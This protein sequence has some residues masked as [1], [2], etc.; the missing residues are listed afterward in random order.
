MTVTTTEPVRQ[1]DRV[2]WGDLLWLTWRQHRWS[3]V[4]LTAL[5]GAFAV[6]W[7]AMAWVVHD[8]GTTQHRIWLIGGLYNTAQLVSVL[9]AFVGL[10]IAVFWA[11]PLLSREYEQKTHVVV[12]TQDLAPTR[13]LV[14]KAVLLGVPAI[15]LAAG[16]G[17]SVLTLLQAIRSVR[18]D[19]KAFPAFGFASFEAEPF[20]QVGFAAFGFALGLAFSALTRRTVL[21]MGLT[22]LVF[23]AVRALV[24]GLWRPYYRTPERYLEPYRTEGGGGYFSRPELRQAMRVD[25]GYANAAGVE[26]QY[27][28]EC[29]R[30]STVQAGRSDCMNEHGVFY[31]FTDYQPVDRLV[32]FQLIE[33]AIFSVLA[34]GLFTLTYRWVKRS[35]RF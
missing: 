24:A 18:P 32:S 23:S 4:G 5:I 12:W 25:T 1:R 33:L 6:T 26:V 20:V 10:V 27:P 17:A 13:W 8:S 30:V 7:L 16:F 3:I 19:Q 22:L 31:F 35:H 21:A 34:A 14:G 28:T 11:A 2:G 29:L 9:P 15:G